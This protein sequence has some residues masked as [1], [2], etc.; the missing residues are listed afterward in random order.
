M[1]LAHRLVLLV[2]LLQGTATVTLWTLN[3]TGTAAQAVFGI[4]LAVDLLGFALVSYLYRTDKAKA[5]FSR[6]WFLVGCGM[7]VVLFLAVLVLA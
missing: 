7:L 2:V 3:P 6:P 4:L 1:N 5:Q